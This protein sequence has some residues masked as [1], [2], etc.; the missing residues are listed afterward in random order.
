LEQ[1][2]NTRDSAGTGGR[3]LSTDSG[4]V[5]QQT[6]TAFRFSDGDFVA[7]PQ[8]GGL[9]NQVQGRIF[10]GHAL[11]P[12]NSNPVPVNRRTSDWFTLVLVLVVLAFT[13]IRV[14][15]NKILR[16]L[17]SAFF[18]NTVSNQV[19]RDE[20]ILVQ[21]ASILLSFIF[22]LSA[23]L[24]LY[25]VSVYYNWDYAFMGDGFLRF[26]V[27]SLIVAF[28]YSF[29]MVLLKGM[30]AVFDIDKPI[31]TYIFNIF[32][33]NNILG[34]VMIPLVIMLAFVVVNSAG[35]WIV[36]GIAIVIISFIYR[37]VRAFTIWMYMPGVPIFYLFL[38][39]CTLE[40][41]PLLLV[42]KL[43]KG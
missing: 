24:F 37:L 19:V 32:L 15:Y 6:D 28:A 36:A 8:S 25:Q 17:V 29:K 41:A 4:V 34:L 21:R 39:F 27:L 10:E 16:Q 2:D 18:S 23:S 38:Y 13:W 14:F 31:A 42:I 11:Q 26:L 5:I 22:Y 35:T 33:I 30:A 1:Q 20:N 7:D 9:I 43:A 3:S 40:I 12:V